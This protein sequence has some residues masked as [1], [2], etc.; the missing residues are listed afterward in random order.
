MSYI[1]KLKCDACNSIF[2]IDLEDYDLSWEIADSF[3]RG[4]NAM[5]EEIHHEAIIDVECPDCGCDDIHVSLNIWEYPLGAYN[6]Q[7]I[8]VEGAELVKGC[9]IQGLSPIGE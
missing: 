2:D 8:E 4:D 5:G 6:D 9:D 3:D 7:Q 1:L